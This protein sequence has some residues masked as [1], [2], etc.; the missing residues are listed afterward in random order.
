MK[1]IPH[2]RRQYYS[3]CR[4]F[5]QFRYPSGYSAACLHLHNM[6]ETTQEQAAASR[7]LLRSQSPL[8]TKKC[9]TCTTSTDTIILS[10][11]IESIEQAVES[12]LPETSRPD[13]PTQNTDEKNSKYEVVF[14]NVMAKGRYQIPSFYKHAAVLLL[15]WTDNKDDM[16]V[17]REVDDLAEVFDEQFNYEVE[18]ICLKPKKQNHMKRDRGTNLQIDVYYEVSKFLKH[19]DGPNTLLVVY[20]A[21]HGKPGASNEHLELRSNDAS[22][23]HDEALQQYNTVVWNKTEA[24]LKE[25]M[26]DVLEIFDCCYAGNLGL[27]RSPERTFEYLAATEHDKLTRFPGK[28]SFTAALIWSLKELVRHQPEGRF[29]TYDLCKKIKEDAPNFPREEQTPKLYPRLDPRS[30]AGRLMLHPLARDGDPMATTDLTDVQTTVHKARETLNLK[31]YFETRMAEQDVTALGEALNDMMRRIGTSIPISRI[32]WNGLEDVAMKYAKR[33]MEL[34][35]DSKNSAS[36][37]SATPSSLNSARSQFVR[38]M[39]GS[40]QEKLRSEHSKDEELEEA[41]IEDLG[42]LLKVF[43][44]SMWRYFHKKTAISQQ[45]RTWPWL[46]II[47]VLVGFSILQ[48]RILGPSYIQVSFGKA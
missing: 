33:W 29:T 9:N 6:A 28:H 46:G 26:A 11:S 45:R 40:V 7:L 1:F 44:S 20:Y 48:Y 34:G 18:K 10:R 36:P 32:S 17:Q 39:G 41:S 13:E 14:T 19:H 5:V 38:R 24:V 27:S 21:G 8:G 16:G 47:V 42:C 37:T 30:P 43:L 12:I 4:N 23:N 31:F 15:S 35:R 22:P 2:G 25:A 3:Y